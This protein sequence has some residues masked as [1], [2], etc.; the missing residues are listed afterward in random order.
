VAIDGEDLSLNPKKFIF[1]LS[2]ISIVASSGSV[3]VPTKTSINLQ[4]CQLS[5]W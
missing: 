1:E 4:P 2:Q 5:D 3:A